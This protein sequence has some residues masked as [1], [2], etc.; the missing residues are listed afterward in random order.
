MGVSKYAAIAAVI[1]FHVS[2]ES[3]TDLMNHVMA[4]YSKHARPVKN[5][6]SDTVNVNMSFVMTSIRGFDEIDGTANI[7][8]ILYSSW[9]DFRISWNPNL[10]RGINSLILPVID[11]W[12]PEVIL[13]N[14]SDSFESLVTQRGFVQYQPNGNAFWISQSVFRVACAINIKYY[15]FDIQTIFLGFYSMKYGST[16]VKLYS[17]NDEADVQYY[18]KN[19]EW[20]LIRSEALTIDLGG[21]MFQVKLVLARRPMFVVVILIL[22][23]LVMGLLNTLVFLLPAA[24]GERVSYSI[25]ILLSQAIFLTIV[26]DNIPKTSKPV[27]ILCYFIGSQLV[28]SS[29]TCIANVLNLRL[30]YVN[31]DVPVAPFPRLFCQ[32]CNSYQTKHGDEQIKNIYNGDTRKINNNDSLIQERLKNIEESSNPKLTRKV[33]SLTID[34]FLC[35]L[36]LAYFIISCV[37][38]SFLLVFRDDSESRDYYWVD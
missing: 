28:M 33:V 25:T 3:M 19:G 6:T 27:S 22:P 38:F 30:F 26:S 29:L 21:W 34:R 15:P 16:E 14:P 9:M 5:H 18:I 2:A 13:S 7:V 37:V 10:Y 4:G 20:D 36:S 1:V 35:F 8:G 11:V 24:S 23:V 32:K 31:G 17:I 12:T